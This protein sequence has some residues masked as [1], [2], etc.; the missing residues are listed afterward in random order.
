MNNSSATSTWHIDHTCETALAPERIWPLFE[1][2]AGWKRWNPGV[3]ESASEG[4]FAAGTWFSMKPPEQETLRSRLTAV[5]A[6]ESFVD[7]TRV[8]DLVVTVTH[9]LERLPEATTRITYSVDAVGPD[10]GEIGPMI[11]ADF[12]EVLA[13]LVAYAGRGQ[14]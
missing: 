8:G 7:E 11:A 2:I 14:P 5:H 6:G 1:D 12:P 13:S 3:E 9:R 4:P 10:A